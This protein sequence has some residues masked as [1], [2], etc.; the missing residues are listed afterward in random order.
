MEIATIP[1]IKRSIT[2]EDTNVDADGM[3]FNRTG[4]SRWSLTC[5]GE[6]SYGL[7]KDSDG[8]YLLPI[9]CVPRGKI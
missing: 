1:G 4:A 9:K 8:I 5:N 6:G 7:N 3:H 2:G